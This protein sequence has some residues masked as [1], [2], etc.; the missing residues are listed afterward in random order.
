MS[1]INNSL[2]PI[3]SN[4]I[5]FGRCIVDKRSLRSSVLLPDIHGGALF[6]YNTPCV[7]TIYFWRSYS[8]MSIIREHVEKLCNH[9]YH[10]GPSFSKTEPPRLCEASESLSPS[11][12][13]RQMDWE[14][15][16]YHVASKFNGFDPLVKICFSGVTQRAWYTKPKRKMWTNCVAE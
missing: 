2:Y 5:C 1:Y 4:I 3:M 6:I 16:S 8:N 10:E 7:R 15:S 12:I 9:G 11:A 13:W 14:R